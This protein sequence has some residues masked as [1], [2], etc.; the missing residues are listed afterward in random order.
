MCV[1]DDQAGLV[2]RVEAAALLRVFGDGHEAE[3]TGPEGAVGVRGAHGGRAEFATFGADTDF[4]AGGELAA[5]VDR[6]RVVV[7]GGEAVAEAFFEE[8]D[9]ALAVGREAELRAEKHDFLL[10]RLAEWRGEGQE[11]GHPTA[12]DVDAGRR[13]RG[14]AGVGQR[15]LVVDEHVEMR[16]DGIEARHR[17]RGFVE[18]VE[19]DA[20]AAFFEEGEELGGDLAEA[21]ELLA[22]DDEPDFLVGGEGYLQQRCQAGAADDAGREKLDLRMRERGEDAGVF[23]MPVAIESSHADDAGVVGIGHAGAHVEVGESLQIGGGV[24]E[25]VGPRAIVDDADAAGG[26]RL[27][28]GGGG[29]FGRKGW[30]WGE[31]R[32][33]SGLRAMPKTWRVTT[34]RR[35]GWCDSGWAARTP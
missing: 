35:S 29:A 3:A 6:Q 8:I 4:K 17:A 28:H 11:V 23:G 25:L 7:D 32:R 2:E 12:V 24:F 30:A 21:F 31:L 10:G 26:G 14:A 19:E 18:C 5:R 9:L 13:E 22:H 33:V 1:A 20:Q 16:S 34:R 15:R 27:G